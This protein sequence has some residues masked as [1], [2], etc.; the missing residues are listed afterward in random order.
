MKLFLKIQR[1]ASSIL[2]GFGFGAFIFLTGACGWIDPPPQNPYDSVLPFPETSGTHPSFPNQPSAPGEKA[3][4]VK[5]TQQYS[6]PHFN[7]QLRGF[8]SVA[9]NVSHL[10]NVG[11]TKEQFKQYGSGVLVKGSVFFEGGQKLDL[12]NLNQTLTVNSSS[13][14]KI[15]VRPINQSALA[16][17]L[18]ASPIAGQVTGNIAVLS[19]EDEKGKVTLDGSFRSNDKGL[20][21]F[22]APF[23]Y[24]NFTAFGRTDISGYSGTVGLFEIPVCGL[25]DCAK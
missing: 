3:G 9:G 18:N 14:I 21:V 12:S 22:S 10:E 2:S 25:F 16:V 5:C 19:F 4:V 15:I 24:E 6:P 20:L 11:C 23:R 13:K 17:D 7:Q 8:L 1:R